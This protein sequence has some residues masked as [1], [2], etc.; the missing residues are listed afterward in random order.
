MSV[1]IE[2]VHDAEELKA[3]EEFRQVLVAEDLLPAKHDD[4]HMMLRFLKARKFEID[5]SKLMWSDMLKWRKEF[6]ADTIGE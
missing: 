4:Y 5:K 3:V 6:G 2:D 1:E